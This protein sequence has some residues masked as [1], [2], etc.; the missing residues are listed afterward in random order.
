MICMAMSGN[1]AMIGM[2]L[3]PKRI[4]P[5]QSAPEVAKSA[6]AEV[7]LISIKKLVCGPHSGAWIH[8]KVLTD[9]LAFASPEP[10]SCLFQSSTFPKASL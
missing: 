8:P 7:V 2:D 10:S 1:G 3:I 9:C 4:S 6:F 5:T